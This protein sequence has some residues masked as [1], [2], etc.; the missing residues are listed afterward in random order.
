MIPEDSM[1]QEM[2]IICRACR[3]TKC[4]QMGMDRQAVQPRRDRNAGR[5]KISH[6]NRSPPQQQSMDKLASAMKVFLRRCTL[7]HQIVDPC[8]LTMRLGLPN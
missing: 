1:Q 3:Y 2:R 7:F 6:L 5:R 4:I 8:Y